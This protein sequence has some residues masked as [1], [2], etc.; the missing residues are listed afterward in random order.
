MAS[1]LLPYDY[2]PI[3]EHGVVVDLRTGAL[4]ATDG[5]VVWPWFEVDKQVV[6]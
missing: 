5:T 1:V 2:D 4:V 6:R 3:A